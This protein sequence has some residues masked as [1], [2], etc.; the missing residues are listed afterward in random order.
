MLPPELIEIICEFMHCDIIEV[1]EGYDLVLRPCSAFELRWEDDRQ[2][3]F[4]CLPS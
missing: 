1:A 4:A 2:M 3:V